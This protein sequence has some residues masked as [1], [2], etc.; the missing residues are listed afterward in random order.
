MPD[1]GSIGCAT[2][3]TGV[4]ERL[5]QNAAALGLMSGARNGGGGPEEQTAVPLRTER[6]L[7]HTAHG[8][9]VSCQPPAF[10]AS[11]DI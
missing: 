7:S 3:R 6:R 9:Y 1:A 10:I 8:P 2:S 11:D 4:T 5:W